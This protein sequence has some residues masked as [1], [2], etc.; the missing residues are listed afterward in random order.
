MGASCSA[1]TRE[2]AQR[3]IGAAA[4]CGARDGRDGDAPDWRR[5]GGR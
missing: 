4:Y 2:V 5:C 1:R 3:L